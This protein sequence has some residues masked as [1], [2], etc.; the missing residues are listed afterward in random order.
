MTDKIILR[1]PLKLLY[2]PHCRAVECKGM[3][4]QYEI[5]D[6]LKSEAI[7]TPKIS[8][9]RVSKSKKEVMSADSIVPPSKEKRVPK[10]KKAKKG[11]PSA[12]QSKQ[13]SA[14]STYGDN[15]TMHNTNESQ[16]YTKNVSRD[17]TGDNYDDDDAGTTYTVEK[18]N[19][20]KQEKNKQS[21][22]GTCANKVMW[23]YILLA[24]LL[25]LL[26]AAIVVLIILLLK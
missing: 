20:M 3:A 11:N 24:I 16:L 9:K 25:A 17:D 7:Q 4:N 22:G 21:K 15:Q 1:L 13:I 8:Q 6:N 26:I 12:E 19:R 10:S 14:D 5:V 23:L 18:G 2:I